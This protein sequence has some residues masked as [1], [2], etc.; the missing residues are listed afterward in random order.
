MKRFT[1][2]LLPILLFASCNSGEPIAGAQGSETETL[3]SETAENKEVIKSFIIG[4]GGGFTGLY[5]LYRVSSNGKIELFDEKENTYSAHGEM[6]KS[7][8]KDIFEE[9]ESLDLV[10]YE[11]YMPGNLNYRISLTE[12]GRTNAITW[13]AS[14]SPDEKILFFYKK[15]MNAIR[16]MH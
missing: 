6:P 12:E 16:S 1:L 13:S 8:A 2:L 9:I 11:F 3:N 15:V 10:N 7:D 4:E 5:T 14:H